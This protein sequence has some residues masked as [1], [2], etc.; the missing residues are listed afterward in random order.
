MTGF[1]KAEVQFNGKNITVEVKSL[2][3]KQL[4]LNAKIPMIYRD[5]EYEIRNLL[6]NKLIRGKVD[7]Y[8]NYD[9]TKESTSLP[10]N[11]GVFKSYYEQI[12][13]ISDDCKI[14][15]SEEPIFQTILRL[16][17]VLKV[18][19]VE[20]SE[21][22]WKLLFSCI[23]KALEKMLLFRQQEGKALEKD[24]IERVRL[25]ES[26][27][28]QVEPFEK[29]RIDTVKQRLQENLKSLSSDIKVDNDRF[30]QEIIY[31]LEKMDVTEEKVRLKNHCE[32]FISTANETHAVGRKLGFILQEMGREINT[33]GSKANQTDIQKLVVLMKDELEKIKEQS[34]NIL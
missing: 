5:R 32:Y 4:D 27:L 18:E 7:F 21:D 12:Q 31:Y 11:A 15:L 24:I 17:D 29:Q 26:L 1:G 19:K 22:E 28:S 23:E 3:S 25:I 10:I 14:T 9:E 33:L 13:K 34:L 2:N 20:V 8:I 30:E 16:P 6:S